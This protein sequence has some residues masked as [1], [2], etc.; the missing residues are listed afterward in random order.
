MIGTKEKQ[1]TPQAAFVFL[2]PINEQVGCE[3]DGQALKTRTCEFLIKRK[4]EKGSAYY[5]P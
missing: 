2:V 1:A 3:A 4:R 5:D